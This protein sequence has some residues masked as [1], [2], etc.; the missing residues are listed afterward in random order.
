M[1][2]TFSL[3]LGPASQWE[4]RCGC[5]QHVSKAAMATRLCGGL[6]DS[7]GKAGRP[8]R[9]DKQR[10]RR[11]ETKEQAKWDGSRAAT[12]KAVCKITFFL[13]LFPVD[14]V[15]VMAI[16]R[17]WE[18]RPSFQSSLGFAALPDDGSRGWALAGVSVGQG[19]ALTSSNG[20]EKGNI[21]MG[22]CPRAQLITLN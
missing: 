18:G 12:G 16:H 2:V 20:A 21:I 17:L 14:N 9:M 6:E 5:Q 10:P 22:Q 11:Q 19:S 13:D 8:G 1:Q 15:Q 7:T 3:V 4:S